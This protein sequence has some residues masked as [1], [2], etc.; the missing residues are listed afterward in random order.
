LLGFDQTPADSVNVLVEL[1]TSMRAHRRGGALLVVPPGRTSWTASIVSPIAYSVTPPFIGLGQV[2]RQ[3]PAR[4]QL[5]E[6]QDS[7][8]RAVETIAGLTAVDGATVLTSEYDLLAFGAKIAR[9]VGS[10]RIEQVVVSEPVVGNA[11]QTLH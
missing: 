9:K 7:F 11:P 6:W 5:P 4:H 1:A 10:P 3:D 8:H 2:V